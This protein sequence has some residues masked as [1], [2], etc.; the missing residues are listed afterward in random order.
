MKRIKNLNFSNH[1]LVINYKT[2]NNAL[3]LNDSL[4]GS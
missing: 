3:F 2:I 1:L 4:S